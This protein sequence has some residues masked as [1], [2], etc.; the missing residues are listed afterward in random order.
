MKI[1]VPRYIRI[2]V[3][4][5]RISFSRYLKDYGEGDGATQHI[6]QELIVSPE[7]PASQKAVTLMHE[8][9]HLI[10]KNYRCQLEEP[11][12]D[13]LAE[14]LAEFLL[15]NLDIEFVWSEIVEQD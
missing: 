11:N 13:R 5:Y 3:H 12:I 14:G 7:L 1:K 15:N 10:N 9:L 4:S 8:A 2:G 6:R